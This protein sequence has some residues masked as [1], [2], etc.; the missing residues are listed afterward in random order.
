MNHSIYT[1]DKAT[2]LKVVVSVL[3]ASIAIVA[4]TLTA[5]PPHPEM[6]VKATTQTVYEPRLGHAITEVA[7]RERH[8]I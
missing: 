7:R 4:T 6:I 3:L 1:A 8:P 5:R 2:H